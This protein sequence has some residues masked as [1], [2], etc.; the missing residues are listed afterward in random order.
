MQLHCSQVFEKDDQTLWSKF[1]V[2]Q[3]IKLNLPSSSSC[4]GQPEPCSDLGFFHSIYLFS[5]DCDTL[6]WSTFSLW[7]EP[8]LPKLPLCVLLPSSSFL[9]S[10][11]VPCSYCWHPKRNKQVNLVWRKDL[12]TTTTTVLMSSIALAF[13]YT[14]Q[15]HK[16]YSNKW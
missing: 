4:S 9:L 12:K 10:L 3:V 13:L 6:D 16:T 7:C 1:L 8:G 11:Q 14:F 5:Q 2:F 15:C